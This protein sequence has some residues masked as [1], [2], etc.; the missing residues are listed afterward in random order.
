MMDGSPALYYAQ[1]AWAFQHGNPKQ[2]NNWV[3]N[4][5]NLYSAELNRAYA[6]PFSDLGWVNNAHGTLWVDDACAPDGA[7]RSSQN[8]S[9]AQRRR[10]VRQPAE[11]ASPS[12]VDGANPADNSR[13]VAGPTPEVSATPE[14]VAN[15][16]KTRKQ[17]SIASTKAAKKRSTRN[18]SKD[19]ENVPVSRSRR[20]AA[21]PTAAVRDSLSSG[22]GA[23]SGGSQQTD[24]PESGRQGCA[25]IA[26]S[27]S[28]PSGKS[29]SPGAG[30][31]RS[32]PKT[33]R[34]PHSVAEAPAEQ[35]ELVTAGG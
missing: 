31:I 2:G 35:L 11:K 25:G 13:P 26:L 27:F 22:R 1:A 24:T 20:T 16:E 12:P 21:G 9:H 6:A 23:D 17:S 32:R 30:R 34:Q 14:K 33:Q 5:S 28:A 7:E 18:K 8:G 19:E 4:A 29:T 3:A 15:V 10:Y